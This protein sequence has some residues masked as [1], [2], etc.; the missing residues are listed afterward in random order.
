MSVTFLEYWSQFDREL[1][2]PKKKK[3]IHLESPQVH[4]SRKSDLP[5]YYWEAISTLNLNSVWNWSISFSG[6]QPRYEDKNFRSYLHHCF[7]FLIPHTWLIKWK[8][9]HWLRLMKESV[10]G[11]L[12]DSTANRHKTISHQLHFVYT[13]LQSHPSLSLWEDRSTF[14]KSHPWTGIS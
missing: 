5:T 4:S 13:Y 3:K 1:T 14:L 6:D 12:L 8:N 7:F 10:T 2:W 11:F 9:K